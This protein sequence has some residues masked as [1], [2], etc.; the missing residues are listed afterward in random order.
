MYVIKKERR[1]P[2]D[3]FSLKIIKERIA[4]NIGAELTIMVAL[5]T[6][7][8][9][10]LKCHKVRSVVNASDANAVYKI[11]LLLFTLKLNLLLTE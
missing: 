9:V 10:I 11:V 1:K 6:D 7:V 3:N 8:I 4:T 5:D 2:F